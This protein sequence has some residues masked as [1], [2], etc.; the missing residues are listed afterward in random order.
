M[1][2]HK[3][4]IF[5]G[6]VI[7]SKYNCTKYASTIAVHYTIISWKCPEMLITTD[8]CILRFLDNEKN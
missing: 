1:N 6:I 7:Q 3:G 2:K 8:I 5:N 4:N